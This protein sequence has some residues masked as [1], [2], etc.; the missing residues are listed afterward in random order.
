[1]A[2][3]IPKLLATKNPISV[4]LTISIFSLFLVNKVKSDFSVNFPTFGPNVV[5]DIAFEND[6]TLSKGAIQLTKKNE[7]GNPLPHSVGQ[8]G[9][10]NPIRLYDKSSGQ[11]AD[12]TTEFSFVVNKKGRENHGD[13]FAFII[14]TPD[15]EFPDPK[16]SAGGFLGMFTRETAFNSKHQEVVLVE[17]DTYGDE[18]D[19][20]PNSQS[21]HVGIDVS[22]IKSVVTAPWFNDITPDGIVVTARIEYNSGAKKL[23]VS[24]TYPGN[25]PLDSRLTL[26]IDLTTILPEKVQIGFS[27]STGD[28]V[29][30][31]DILS[32]SFHSTL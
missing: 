28:L 3:S 12:F 18:W 6:A 19:P 20:V 25:V 4:L 9:L 5:K 22:S 26:D 23:S 32:W 10:F 2:V 8:S 27:G 30:T 21:P 31:H 14:V 7:I 13:G 1:M 17:F 15:F 11:V 24:V 29:E 16:E